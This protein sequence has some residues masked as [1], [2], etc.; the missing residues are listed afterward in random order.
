M[1]DSLAKAGLILT[2]VFVV[3]CRGSSGTTDRAGVAAGTGRPQGSVSSSTSAIPA[4]CNDYVRIVTQCI[5]TKLPES[6]RAEERR[7]LTTFKK[8]L[9]TCPDAAAQAAPQ[10][11]ANLR[12]EFRQDSYGCYTEEAV[13][14]GV[15]M[16]CSLLT[17]AEL[18]T[19]VG[20]R[21][22]DGVPDNMRCR[23]AFA[24]QPL[25]HPLLITVRWQGGRDD[26]EAA[27]GAQAIVNGRLGKDTGKSDI[28]PGAAVDGVGDE[29]FFTLAG[30]WPMLQA[31]LGDVSIGV[32]GLERDQMI[33]I[34]RMALP[35]ITPDPD[36][37]R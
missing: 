27:R 2:V 37:Q 13:R 30:I 14:R 10:C 1:V 12:T 23:Y 29:A 11:A 28:V 36:D 22:E 8:M 26:V 31:R 6:E 20:A 16:A 34:A 18:E 9:D 32:E 15:Q 19:I 33:A 3:A 4:A 17:R 21:L 24:G 25:R 35:R 5:E 7:K